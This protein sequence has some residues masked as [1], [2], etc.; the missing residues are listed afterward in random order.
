M[1]VIFSDSRIQNLECGTYS[2]PES[3]PGFR[4]STESADVVIFPY[5]ERRDHPPV[6]QG[7]TKISPERKK[8]P[9]TC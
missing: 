7:I 3:L 5:L 1:S 6:L 4:L 2:I 9:D 8:T